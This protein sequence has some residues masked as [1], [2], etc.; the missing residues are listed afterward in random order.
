M[1]PPLRPANNYV[2]IIGVLN[3]T[4]DFVNLITIG[5]LILV[6]SLPLSS[7]W[8]AR[9][10]QVMKQRNPLDRSRSAWVVPV[11]I[12]TQPKEKDLASDLSSEQDLEIGGNQL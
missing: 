8:A 7:I 6:C 3:L 11:M 2:V 10:L 9:E 1:T 4:L 5:Q 12:S